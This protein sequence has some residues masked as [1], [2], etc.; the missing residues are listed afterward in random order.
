MPARSKTCRVFP[1][2]PGRSWEFSL[3]L[4]FC[5]Y[6]SSG[7]PGDLALGRAS[8]SYAAH[9]FFVPLFGDPYLANWLFVF[10]LFKF[11]ILHIC[12]LLFLLGSSGPWRYLI[13]F[14]VKFEVEYIKIMSGGPPGTRD[15]S[16]FVKTCIFQRTFGLS[17]S[18]IIYGRVISVEISCFRAISV[19]DKLGYQH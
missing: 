1:I 7:H 16:I 5:N 17:A 13:L 8:G 12:F 11:N 15:M 10:L 6:H 19:E 3:I 2:V 18:K 4:D 14:V 9:V